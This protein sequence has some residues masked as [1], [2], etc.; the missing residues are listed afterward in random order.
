ML[1][2]ALPA[3]FQKIDEPP[4]LDPSVPTE[5]TTKVVR[6]GSAVTPG[7]NLAVSTAESSF[8][9]T[10]ESIRA[11]NGD[12]S[13]SNAVVDVQGV[14]L[15]GTP[16]QHRDFR[17]TYSVRS[18]SKPES[19]VSPVATFQISKDAIPR[20]RMLNAVATMNV[21]FPAA[22]GPGQFAIQEAVVGQKFMV[23]LLEPSA[24]ESYERHRAFNVTKST[25]EAAPVLIGSALFGLGITGVG[26][27]VFR[28]AAQ[29][30]KQ[31]V[32]PVARVSSQF[33]AAAL[34][35]SL[36]QGK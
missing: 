29:F 5:L 12:W 14:K 8:K 19:S 21:E 16:E 30:A 25:K 28:R 9:V 35:R 36:G 26:V 4:T 33:D 18:S 24:L 1:G 22:A 10:F 23:C 32:K 34:E 2:I 17:K 27:W 20:G 31:P 7:D 15:I 13:G 11:I 3:L 6:R